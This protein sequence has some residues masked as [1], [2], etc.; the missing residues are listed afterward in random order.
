[1]PTV[2]QIVLPAFATILIGY[3]FGRFRHINISS[4]VDVTINIGVPALV[5]ALAHQ[6]S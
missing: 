3:L 1:M 6:V 5:F 4:I 2:I